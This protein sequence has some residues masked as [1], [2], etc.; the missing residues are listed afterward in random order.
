MDTLETG[1][2]LGRK[3]KRPFEI[4]DCNGDSSEEGEEEQEVSHLTLMPCHDLEKAWN[5]LQVRRSKEGEHIQYEPDDL[6]AK[7]VLDLLTGTRIHTKKEPLPQNHITTNIMCDT[8][9]GGDSLRDIG[10]DE[11][12]DIGG[13]L[14]RDN[15]P[16]CAVHDR[17]PVS[18]AVRYF[19]LSYLPLYL[20]SVTDK[21]LGVGSICSLS[22]LLKAYPSLAE[23][24]ITQLLPLPDVM[25]SLST[26]ITNSSPAPEAIE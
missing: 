26:V 24:F 5:I 12:R 18:D 8:N 2:S 23:A 20:S 9:I 22:A 19:L 21:E 6:G 14:V 16:I 15:I 10:A 17:A 4:L 1:E 7:R 11:L 13:D 25:C 3:R